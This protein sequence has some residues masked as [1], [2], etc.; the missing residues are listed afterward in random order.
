MKGGNLIFWEMNVVLFGEEKTW[1]GKIRDE[2][3]VAG[4]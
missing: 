1:G 2:M 3:V 4:G